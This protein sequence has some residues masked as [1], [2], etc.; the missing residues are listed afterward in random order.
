MTVGEFNLKNVLI[1][2]TSKGIG[3]SLVEYFANQNANV[4]A[5]S[6]T[7]IKSTRENV[8]S[9]EVSIGDID[10]ICNWLDRENAGIDILINNAGIICYEELLNVTAGQISNIFSTNV[11]ST[12]LLSQAIVKRMID[13]KKQG[14]I[15]NTISFAAKIPSVGSGIYAASK[16]ALESLTRTMAAEWAPFGI[17]VNGYSPGVIKTDMTESAIKSNGEKML[18]AIALRKIGMTE[19]IVKAVAFLASNDSS[20][21]TGINLD[22]SGGKFIVQNSE[23]AWEQ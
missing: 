21:I 10:T 1:T 2:G 16:A 9:I 3:R 17:R 12:L 8:K 23:R 15:V 18:D 19:D 11:T 22:V 7:K 5:I 14:V 6:R 20:Y 4:Y 13:E